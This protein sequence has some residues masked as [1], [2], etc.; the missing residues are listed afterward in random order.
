MMS[1]RV[2]TLGQ[3]HLHN[4]LSF[5][6]MAMENTALPE[7]RGKEILLAGFPLMHYWEQIGGK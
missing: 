4:F 6:L 3:L 1:H 2:V 7:R 5:G